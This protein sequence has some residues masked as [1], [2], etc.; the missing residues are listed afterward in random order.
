[1]NT[2]LVIEQ[3]TDFATLLRLGR[4]LEV[5]DDL[6]NLLTEIVPQ[7][8]GQKSATSYSV[9]EIFSLILSCQQAED[10]LG[11]ADY[12]EYELSDF[13]IDLS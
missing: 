9:E 2:K 13:L 7:T 12:L 6:I 1:M 4:P 11:L 8:I 3:L 10:W 5:I